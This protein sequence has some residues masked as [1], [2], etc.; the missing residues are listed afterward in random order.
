[1]GLPESGLPPTKT[2]WE[3]RVVT[4]HNTAAQQGVDRQ[5]GRPHAA[6]AAMSEGTNVRV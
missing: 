1:M 3:P 5:S 6:D 4:S 2:S